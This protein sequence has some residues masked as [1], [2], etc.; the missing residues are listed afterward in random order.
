MKASMLCDSFQ[1]PACVCR[2]FPGLTPFHTPA[3]LDAPLSTT[4]TSVTPDLAPM[5]AGWGAPMGD[6]SAGRRSRSS[7]AGQHSSRL[8]VEG[9]VFKR[10]CAAY[11]PGRRSMAWRKVKC[12]AWREVH[13]ER[14]R[15][16]H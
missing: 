12:S 14:R 15:P 1:W 4:V 5:L 8:D 10:L 6:P 3:R 9:V 11:T 2:T 13:A 7:T 16:V